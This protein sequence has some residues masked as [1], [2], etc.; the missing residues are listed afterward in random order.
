MSPEEI[1]YTA[2]LVPSDSCDCEHHAQLL[3]NYAE[4]LHAQSHNK[5]S[6][7]YG[8]LTVICGTF[9]CLITFSLFL[10]LMLSSWYQRKVTIEMMYVATIL[11]LMVTMT[12]ALFGV[13]QKRII[14]NAVDV[15]KVKTD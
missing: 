4:V 6:D 8:R 9:V 12:G 14:Q 7:A 15:I 10:F 13:C 3:R 11:G 5:Q 1:A 2:E